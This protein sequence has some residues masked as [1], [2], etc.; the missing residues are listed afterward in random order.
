MAD[1]SNFKIIRNSIKIL[2]L[3][4]LKNVGCPE[5]S[6]SRSLYTGLVLYPGKDELRNLRHCFISEF[7]HVFHCITFK[8]KTSTREL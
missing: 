8:K 3:A 7:L 1:L 4:V 6:F 2:S 5:I